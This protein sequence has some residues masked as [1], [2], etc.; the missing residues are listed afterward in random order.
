MQYKT[1][2]LDKLLNS[3]LLNIGKFIAKCL[4]NVQYC[5]LVPL[6]RLGTRLAI[7]LHIR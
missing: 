6:M 4:T 2:H 5:S 3:L 7:L 1:E